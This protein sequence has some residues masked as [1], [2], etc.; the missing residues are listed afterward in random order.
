MKTIKFL[1]LLFS[2]LFISNNA[3]SHGEIQSKN[4]C[5]WGWQYKAIARVNNGPGIRRQAQRGC[6][7]SYGYTASVSYPCVS[8]WT[9]NTG[10]YGQYAGAVTATWWLCG[11]GFSNSDLFYDLD[12]S[13]EKE[14]KSIYEESTLK[15]NPVKFS[16]NIVTI[17]NLTGRM[18]V[19]DKDIFSSLEIIVWQPTHDIINNI[20][21]TIANKSEYLWQGKIELLNG[22]AHL[23]GDFPENS[24]RIIKIENGYE[25]VF[26]NETITASLPN[27][28]DGINDDIVVSI[29]TDGGA[30][31]TSFLSTLEK[32]TT[33]NIDI[34]F[35]TFPNPTTDIVN[36]S[37]NSKTKETGTIKVYNSTGKLISVLYSG[38]F[39]N[40]I[41]TS[42][43]FSESKLNAGIYFILIQSQNEQYIKKII[44][45]K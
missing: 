1:G 6:S 25:V 8:Q 29:I 17:P 43:N 11:R 21:D 27:E 32:K 34:Q 36:I 4:K 9:R 3:F 2:I 41:N 12:L 13:S 19:S 38:S 28:I 42:Y 26:N 44:Y 22:K 5:R 10:G 15:H 24:Y 30:K 37:F 7:S 39:E 31:E 45:K 14:S 33:S 23:T 18:F 35:N 16:E 40:R 20:E